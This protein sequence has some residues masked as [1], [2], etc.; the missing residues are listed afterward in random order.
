MQI[1][2]KKTKFKERKKKKEILY[3]KVLTNKWIINLINKIDLIVI[4]IIIIIIE[5][6]SDL[7][8]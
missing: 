8:I 1:I 3:Q 2:I 7:F 4:V 6:V 5:K